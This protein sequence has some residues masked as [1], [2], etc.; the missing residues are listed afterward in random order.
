MGSRVRHWRDQIS[1]TKLNQLAFADPHVYQSLYN[2]LTI[3]LNLEEID[4]VVELEDGH[5]PMEVVV[6]DGLKLLWHA[7]VGGF[8]TD[9]SRHVFLHCYLLIF[10]D[11]GIGRSQCFLMWL[12]LAMDEPELFYI[13]LKHKEILNGCKSCLL[14]SQGTF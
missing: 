8:G 10:R 2:Q 12:M 13:H 14:T 5:V 4:I 11:L 7:I 1:H 9:R 6:H 3:L